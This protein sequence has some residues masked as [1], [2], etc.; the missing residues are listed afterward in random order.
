MMG[1]SMPSAEAPSVGAAGARAAPL[2]GVEPGQWPL[3][4][5]IVPVFEHAERLPACL[6][7]L[8]AQDYLGTHEVVVVDN[9]VVG[10]IH[11]LVA[12]WDGVRLVREPRQGS[13]AARNRGVEA[14]AG[15]YLAFTDADCV[16]AP[17]WLR[18]GVR[19]LFDDP[20]CGLVAGRI[21][22][23]V[24]D[25]HHPTAAELYE[26]VASFRQREY[27]ERWR[28]GA[29]ANLFTR[30][31]VF[32]R[33]GPFDERLPSL[34]DRDWGRRVWEAGFA[35]RYADEATVR[36]P[37]R[38]SLGELLRR[39]M[40]MTGGY[41][42]LARSRRL[43]PAALLKDAS[44]GLVPRSMLAGRPCAG[45]ARRLPRG[46]REHAAVIGVAGAVVAVRVLELAR[47]ALGGRPRR[48]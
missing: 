47:L 40:R 26:C 34:G 43:S 44:L 12:Q 8:A 3:V 48:A 36:H 38:R 14:A 31:E 23:E 25:L 18:A 45:E 21:R 16:P 1:A 6:A 39:A 37:A 15:D 28:F 9:G 42:G 22:V 17:G 2:A 33:V 29:T 30:R 5:V 32:A 41:Y 24:A 13:Y 46:A 27:V 4:S 35:L 11:A 7:A 10:G 20:S 19:G